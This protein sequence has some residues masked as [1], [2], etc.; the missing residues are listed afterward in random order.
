MSA[1]DV[2]I[3]SK[4]AGDATLGALL[5]ANDA[6]FPFLAPEDT[7]LPY[8]V[9]AFRDPHQDHYVFAGRAYETYHYLV[10]GVTGPTPDPASAQAI[11]ARIDVLLTGALTTV[12]GYTVMR[13]QREGKV[14]YPEKADT[15]DIYWHNGGLFVIEVDPT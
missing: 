6:V 13:C 4:L 9:Y 2:A 5:S 12:T 15:G 1:V 8:V 10:K 3:Y 7:A 14:D 11:G